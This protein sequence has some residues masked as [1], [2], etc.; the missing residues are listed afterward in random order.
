LIQ[1]KSRARE[2]GEHL[3]DREAPVAAEQVSGTW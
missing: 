1:S 3:I 2:I